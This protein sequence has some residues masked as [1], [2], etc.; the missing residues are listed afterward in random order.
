MKLARNMETPLPSFIYFYCF[1]GQIGVAGTG[2]VAYATHFIISFFR[3]FA[4]SRRYRSI[5]FW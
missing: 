4:Q 5:S 3:F 1:D 2:R